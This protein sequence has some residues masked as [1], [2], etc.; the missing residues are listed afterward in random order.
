MADNFWTNSTSQDPKRK[1][2]FTV[3][4]TN[5][6][7]GLIWY[8]KTIS[9]PKVSFGEAEHNFLNHRFYYPGR[10]EWD[11]VTVTLVDPISPD[12]AGS[13]LKLVADAGYALPA[14]ASSLVPGR[15]LSSPSKQTSV[16]ALGE[17][18]FDQIDSLGDSVETWTL[19]NAWL[20]DVA[21]G[22]LDYTSDDLTELTLTVRY[23]WASFE[24]P[25]TGKLFKLQ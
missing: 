8:A 14:G 24:S 10:A 6:G 25:T 7:G 22:D 9:K 13:L 12:A 4:F 17:I 18:K 2:R 15:G 20:K 16:D 21:F 11:P 3:T 5:L 19:N 1:F 23:D